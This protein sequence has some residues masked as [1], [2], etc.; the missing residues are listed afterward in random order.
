MM[1]PGLP[2][3]NAL[4]V[5]TQTV[6][7]SERADP[8]VMRT[9]IVAL[10]FATVPN[11]QDLTSQMVAGEE[12]AFRIF[13]D[14]YCDRLFRYLTVLS[15]GDEELARDLVQ[16]T[17]VKVVRSI[18][19]FDNEALLW[20]WLAAIARNSFLDFIRKARRRPPLDPTF[21][22]LH[23]PAHEQRAEDAVLVNALEHAL[24]QLPSE[25]R[26][27]IESFYFESDSYHA[28]AAQQDTSPKAVESRLA[29]VR[30]KL[31]AIILKYLRY[32][33]S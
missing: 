21:E 19:L 17:M 32:E 10:D 18:R 3:K 6:T 2:L 7:I 8:A 13:H 11:L 12:D 31:R 26:V 28:L 20:N 27:L 14:L 1:T 5:A 15:R 33:N 16:V 29:R 4:G 22:L 24:A 25:D 9:K 23:Y 30:Q